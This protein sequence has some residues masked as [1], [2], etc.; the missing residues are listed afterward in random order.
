MVNKFVTGLCQQLQAINPHNKKA[1]D[2]GVKAQE[3]SKEAEKENYKVSIA[4]EHLNSNQESRRLIKQRMEEAIRNL[5][6]GAS[7]TTKV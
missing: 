2:Y 1:G 5:Q 3:A 7:A 4:D 6:Q